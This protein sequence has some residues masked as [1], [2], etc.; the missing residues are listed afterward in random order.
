M[1]NNLSAI[2]EEICP[3][4]KKEHINIWVNEAINVAKKE[5]DTEDNNIDAESISRKVFYQAKRTSTLSA[6]D[7]SLFIA[8]DEGKG[9]FG[10]NS[11]QTVIKDKIGI[12]FPEFERSSFEKII[13]CKRVAEKRFE[14]RHKDRG[15]T[16][17]TDVIDKVKQFNKEGSTEFP[18]M[19]L[20]VDNAYRDKEDKL[21]ICEYK[22]PTTDNDYNSENDIPEYSKVN[23]EYS[24]TILE[25]LLNEPVEHV[26]TNYF[27][28]QSFDIK[29]FEISE[30]LI[31]RDKIMRSGEKAW[32]H[33]MNNTFPEISQGKDFKSIEDM[34]NILQKQVA[35]TV[36]IKTLLTQLKSN[37]DTASQS[38]MKTLSEYTDTQAKGKVRLP[39]LDVSRE[40]R[41]KDDVKSMVEFLNEKGIDTNLPEF[42]TVHDP[43]A[44]KNAIFKLGVDPEGIEFKTESSFTK[45]TIPTGKNYEYREAIDLLK[46]SVNETTHMQVGQTVS[47]H[48]TFKEDKKELSLQDIDNDKGLAF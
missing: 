44:L 11:P 2:V 1:S 48:F 28:Y 34:P 8:S 27:N 29:S 41:R 13:I 25:N 6:Y 43:K 37:Y 46:D 12:T 20:K 36:V 30:D 9:F 26:I 7:L 45:L 38:L 32:Q 15:L 33:I 23:A 14:S 3:Q 47:E 39:L 10:K 31:L 24:R 4:I 21:W 40:S 22:F 35:N 19:R 16:V 18:W 17:A 42:K 5:L